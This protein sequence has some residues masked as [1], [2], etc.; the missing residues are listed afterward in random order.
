[1]RI[2]SGNRAQRVSAFT[3]LER[4][5]ASNGVFSSRLSNYRFRLQQLDLS[6]GMAKT[7]AS[8][9]V[10]VAEAGTGT[11]KT[12]A[13]LVPALLA[14]GK[15]IVSTG[16]KALQDQ[17]YRRDI[18]AVL[19]ALSLPVKAS[20]LKG[21]ANYVCRHHLERNLAD[22]RFASPEEA[23]TLHRIQRFAAVSGSGVRAGLVAAIGSLFGNLG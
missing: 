13:Y 18:P 9:G 3:E 7:L 6:R 16:T 21:R 10:L 23:A 8:G 20:L 19:E 15:T 14:G 4:I 17:L 22:G 11:G 1:M 2:M 5:F 12:L